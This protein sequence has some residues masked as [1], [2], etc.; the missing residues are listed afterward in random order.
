MKWDLKHLTLAADN[1]LKRLTNPHHR[2]IVA[3]YRLHAMLEVSGRWQEI[4]RPEMTVDRPFYRIS[5]R[6]GVLELDGAEAVQSFYQSLVAARAN[7]IILE[8]E[9][10]VVDDWGFASEALYNTF[11]TGEAARNLG[12]EQAD[13]SKTYIERRWVCMIWPYDAQARMIGERAYLAPTAEL[14]ECPKEDFVTPEDVQRV[15]GPLI[16]DAQA[17]LSREVVRP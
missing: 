8:R 1:A 5:D 16:A 14:V 2:A 11:L 9:E 15:L 17:E 7:V 3:N 12:H 13:I 10:L 6:N 4:F